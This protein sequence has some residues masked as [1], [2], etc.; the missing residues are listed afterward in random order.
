MILCLRRDVPRWQAMGLSI[1]FFKTSSQ[2]I[3][4]LHSYKLTSMY[5]KEQSVQSTSGDC[6]T[7]M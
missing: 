4:D 3:H 1:V 7:Y 2:P 6:I 5:S